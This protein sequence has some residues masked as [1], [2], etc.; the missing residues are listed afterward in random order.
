ML[1]RLL[2]TSSAATTKF[3]IKIFNRHKTSHEQFNVCEIT[4]S[5][6]SQTKK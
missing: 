1:E 5:I 3:L 2:P 6:N 4:K